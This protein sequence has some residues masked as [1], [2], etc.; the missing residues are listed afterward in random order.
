MLRTGRLGCLVAAF[1]TASVATPDVWDLGTDNDNDAGSDNEIV[2]GLDQVHDLA[3]RNGGTVEDADFYAFRHGQGRSYEILVDGIT[4][5]AAGAGGLTVQLLLADGTTVDQ[6][7]VAA[8][9]F[10]MARSLRTFTTLPPSSGTGEMTLFVRVSNPACALTCGA[11]DEYRI[12][13]YDS[14]LTLPRFNNSN[15]QTTVL[16]LQN[17]THRQVLGS[18]RAMSNGGADL[19]QFSFAIS[20]YGTSVTSL[21]TVSG[22]LLSNQS[23]SLFISHNA[24]YGTL[25]GKGVALEPATGFTFDTAVESI[26]Y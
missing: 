8:S 22:G 5:A 16:I 19:G 11:N 21:A 12:R 13:A 23:G 14:T 17:P 4:G 24:G 10:G 26:P 15:G 18:A 1:L 7:S 3:A 20:P 6:D 2:H 25:A 9:S